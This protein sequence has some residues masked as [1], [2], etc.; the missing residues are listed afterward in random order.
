VWSRT[1]DPERVLNINA[2]ASLVCDDIGDIIQAALVK[3]AAAQDCNVI[4]FHTRRKGLVEGAK[5][6]GFHLH[7][8]VCRKYL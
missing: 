6:Y 3:M 8:I 2:V 1:F 4:E 7:S 5:K